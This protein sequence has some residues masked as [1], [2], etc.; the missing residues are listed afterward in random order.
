MKK[1]S[2]ELRFGI[3]L[4]ILSIILYLIHFVV[5]EDVDHIL[6]WSMTSL[7]FLPVSI[8]FVTLIVNKLLIRR[9]KKLR[10]EKLN[11]LIGTFFSEVGTALLE[12][13][14]VKKPILDYKIF[15]NTNP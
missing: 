7:A 2:W 1:S 3:L 6:L 12:F 8:L 4:I 15:P 5:F 11:M 13:F 9:E 14:S 10:L